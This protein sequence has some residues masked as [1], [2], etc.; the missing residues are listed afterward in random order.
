MAVLPIYI[1][2]EKI[3]RKRAREVK[4]I[5]EEMVKLS[6]DMLETMYHAPGIGLAAPQVGQSLRLIVVDVKYHEEETREPHILFNPEIVESEGDSCEEEG[7]L[8]FP[9]IRAMVTRPEKITVQAMG[10]DGKPLVLENISGL[11]SRCIQ[12]EMDHLNGILF[13]DKISNTDKLLLSGKL[14]KLAKETRSS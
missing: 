4:D 10:Q 6:R 7:C 9:D 13:V 14:K 12:H 1:Y 3:L 8:S 11:L 2:G 5:T